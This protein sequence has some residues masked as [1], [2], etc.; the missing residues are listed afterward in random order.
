MKSPSTGKALRGDALADEYGVRAR[1]IAFLIN[2]DET[3]Y[4]SRL[5]IENGIGKK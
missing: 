3:S 4:E 1:P 5:D 2:T